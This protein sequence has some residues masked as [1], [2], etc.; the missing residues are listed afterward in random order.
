MPDYKCNECGR[1]FPREDVFN[2][3]MRIHTGDRRFN[4]ELCGKSF[5]HRYYLTEHMQ[6][7]TGDR[8]FNCEVCGKSFTQRYRL[9]EH[10]R[11]HTGDKTFVCTECQRRFS[12]KTS[13]NRHMTSCKGASTVTT[14]SQVEPTGIMTTKTQTFGSSCSATTVSTVTSHCGAAVV[15]TQYAGATAVTTVAQSGM[16][17]VSSVSALLPAD[18]PL[19]DNQTLPDLG[20][21]TT[22][23]RSATNP[24]DHQQPAEEKTGVTVGEREV[25]ESNS[26]HVYSENV[27]TFI[28]ERNTG[29]SGIMNGTPPLSPEYTVGITDDQFSTFKQEGCSLCHETDVTES[30]LKRSVCKADVYETG[31]GHLFHKGCLIRDFS[32]CLV[33]KR[34]DKRELKPT[35]PTCQYSNPV[36]EEE[37]LLLESALI[38]YACYT[39]GE[40][41]KKEMLKQHKDKGSP[42]V[43]AIQNELLRMK[44]QNDFKT[45]S[46]HFWLEAG[47]TITNKERSE[48]L[49]LSIEE[50]RLSDVKE[51]LEI[52]ATLESKEL[53]ELA[54]KAS[55][56][57]QLNLLKFLVRQGANLCADKTNHHFREA[58][59]NNDINWAKKLKNQNAELPT[60]ELNSLCTEAAKNRKM[61]MVSLLMEY[62]AKP[63]A[64]DWSGVFKKLAD[65]YDSFTTESL[66]KMSIKPDTE[67]L[68]TGFR[69]AVEKG[70]FN[71]PK[72]WKSLGADLD[73]KE[74]NTLLRDAAEK[75]HHT[76]ISTLIKLG[77]KPGTE[78]LRELLNQ[79]V[80][81]NHP[82][83]ALRLIENGAEATKEVINACFGSAVKKHDYS[84]VEDLKH[85]KVDLPPAE[86]N[87]LLT[88]ITG[89]PHFEPLAKIL[90]E[91]GAQP[92]ANTCNYFFKQAGSD[93]NPSEAKIWLDRGARPAVKESDPM[94]FGP[95]N[96]DTGDFCGLCDH[97]NPGRTIKKSEPAEQEKAE[98]WK[99]LFKT[100]ETVLNQSFAQA[101]EHNVP[102]LV[103]TFLTLGLKP[104]PDCIKSGFKG[105][106]T[107]GDVLAAK[108]WKKAGREVGVKF[109]KEERNTG[110]WAAV[111]NRKFTSARQWIK[112]INASPLLCDL[113]ERLS[114]A[115]AENDTDMITELQ[116][117]GAQPVKRNGNTKSDW[118]HFKFP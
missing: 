3:H 4:C 10:M 107:A 23:K 113:N 66:M 5:V 30:R 14:H 86:L 97:H 71:Q 75:N 43:P 72:E 52:G 92:D 118:K 29:R 17:P 22:L 55:D 2:R 34:L 111:E 84:L 64:E 106:A 100:N 69:N 45:C 37:R 13:L 109:T 115:Q 32:K 117:F 8:R 18:F 62:G 89:G 108:K 31:C 9:T 87:G 27:T 19:V 67:H 90:M 73:T 58:I 98:A 93:N 53:N 57:N 95:M 36:S 16:T 99:Q 38:K 39:P 59:R 60:E 101:A 79:A 110:F 80:A 25:T 63:T 56:K 51:L 54:E 12:Q 112:N 65:N 20:L 21:P 46:S 83:L 88:S 7:H 114:R 35:C 70:R 103:E 11:I 78:E 102:Q 41:D 94:R 15:T 26:E 48:L 49:R 42:W 47:A 116:R 50:N 24:P 81:N 96:F 85:Y 61:S 44:F 91:L 40:P 82:R 104:D 68:N 28:M 105:A 77:A 74:L 33:S 76:M 1:V 6:I